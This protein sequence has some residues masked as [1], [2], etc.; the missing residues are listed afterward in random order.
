MSIIEIAEKSLLHLNFLTLQCSTIAKWFHFR[1]YVLK[2]QWHTI[3]C[4]LSV[5][6]FY[7][8]KSNPNRLKN[9]ETLIQRKYHQRRNGNLVSTPQ[10]DEVVIT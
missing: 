7:R 10:I 2:F 4:R 3:S 9:Y 5:A 6:F 8:T 1:Q